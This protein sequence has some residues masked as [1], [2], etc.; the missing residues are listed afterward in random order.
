MAKILQKKNSLLG[1]YFHKNLIIEKLSFSFSL[2]K[3][4]KLCVAFL[5]IAARK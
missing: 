3:N 2:K 5:P 4:N 1:A